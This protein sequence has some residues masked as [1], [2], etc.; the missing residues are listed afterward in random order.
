MQVTPQT[1]AFGSNGDAQW[2]GSWVD[3]S[4]VLPGKLGLGA[5]SGWN[6]GRFL[7]TFYRGSASGLHDEAL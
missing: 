3:A 1:F 7:H 2:V 4:Q 6:A 5:G